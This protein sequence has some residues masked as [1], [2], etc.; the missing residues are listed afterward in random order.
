MSKVDILIVPLEKR[1][2]ATKQ[3]AEH[4]ESRNVHIPN[5]A[6]PERAKNSPELKEESLLKM[7]TP[8]PK[9]GKVDAKETDN[10]GDA[11]KVL[12]PSSKIPAVSSKVIILFFT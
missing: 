7:T 2:S 8:C 5:E 1:N 4:K 6:E 12:Q 3:L 9:T 11:T 10:G